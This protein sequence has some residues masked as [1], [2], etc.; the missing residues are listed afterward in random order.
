MHT[1]NP[2]GLYPKNASYIKIIEHGSY[3]CW[4]CQTAA[5]N[6][7]KTKTRNSHY[8]RKNCEKKYG[9]ILQ[10]VHVKKFER[11]ALAT[12]MLK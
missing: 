3:A 7:K 5:R 9:S 11:N 2:L 4:K 1:Q 10:F 8:W 6:L 12:A